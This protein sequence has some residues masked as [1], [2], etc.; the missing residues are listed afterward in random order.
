MDSSPRTVDNKKPGFVVDKQVCRLDIPRIRQGLT[1]WSV[2]LHTALLKMPGRARRFV[3]LTPLWLFLSSVCY[4]KVHGHSDCYG[5]RCPS[6]LAGIIPLALGILKGEPETLGL[7]WDSDHTSVS[8]EMRS[9]VCALRSPVLECI[10]RVAPGCSRGRPPEDAGAKSA[11]AFLSAELARDQ[12]VGRRTIVTSALE[13]VM[14]LKNQGVCWYAL[15]RRAFLRVARLGGGTA[16][17]AACGTSSAP[18]GKGQ[19]VTVTF[20]TPGGGGDFCTGLDAI[21]RDFEQHHPHIAIA[22]TQCGTG[23]QEF[24]EVLLARIAAG[25]PARCDAPLDLPGRP[26]GPRFPAAARRTDAASTLCAG[27]ELATSSAGELPVRGE[28][29]WSARHRRFVWSLVQPGYV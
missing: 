25:T 8:D 14:S 6:F 28:D 5:L 4:A 9:T 21:A 23:E 27:G 22:E 12:H 26:G 10:W 20:W 13:Q 15:D 7:Q 11:L 19:K 1:C 3:L 29:V 17:L 18:A 16:F 2:T 24:N